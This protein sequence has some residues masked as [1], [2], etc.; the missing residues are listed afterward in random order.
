MAPI[1]LI[2][3]MDLWMYPHH[4]NLTPQN[5]HGSRRPHFSDGPLN[6][7]PLPQPNLLSTLDSLR[8]CFLM[9]LQMP[10]HYLNLTPQTHMAPFVIVFLW[11]SEC[12]PHYL[13]LLNTLDSLSDCFLNGPSNAPPLPQPNPSNTHGSHHPSSFN[14]P[15]N[16]LPLLNLTPKTLMTPPRPNCVSH[17]LRK[18]T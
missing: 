9:G 15:S 2:S 10:P 12:P 11:T 16:T 7:S 3:L 13:N 14:G 1:V 17:S 4:V 6:A 18:H 5:T 8:N